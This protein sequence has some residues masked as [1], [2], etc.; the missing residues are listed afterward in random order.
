[1]NKTYSI[2]PKD[3]NRQWYLLDA[4][5]VTLGRLSTKA[6]KLLL[7]KDKPQYSH[8][9]DCGDYVIIINA[10]KLK[11]TGNKLK[12]KGY[13]RHSQ[14]PGGLHS[15]TLDEQIVKDPTEVIAHSVKGMLPPNK[16]ASARMKRLKI[17]SGSEHSHMPQQPTVISLKK[18]NS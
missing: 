4:S 12:T 14:H 16:L 5:E 17:Y 8:H 13:Y 9:I 7:G 18:G 3:I 2:K 1:M 6:A 15:R 11:I 10:N